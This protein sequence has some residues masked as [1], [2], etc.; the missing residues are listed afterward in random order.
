MRIMIWG[1]QMVGIIDEVVGVYGGVRPLVLDDARDN[2]LS[3]RT[4]WF[5][6]LCFSS[7]SL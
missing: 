2:E 7:A 3:H 4:R 6:R 5:R 1:G